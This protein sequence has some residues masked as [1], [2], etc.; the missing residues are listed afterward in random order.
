M[1]KG[2]FILF[3][4]PNGG[5]RTASTIEEANRALAWLE[6][7]IQ[8]EEV[9]VSGGIHAAALALFYGRGDVIGW[10]PSLSDRGREVAER[11]FR[12]AG[13]VKKGDNFAVALTIRQLVAGKSPA[14]L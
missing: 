4:S 11:I 7:E 9:R 3:I 14:D 12:K 5:V 6:A 1:S 8:P 2:E 13:W 10:S